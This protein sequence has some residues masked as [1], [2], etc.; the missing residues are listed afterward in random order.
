[1]KQLSIFTSLVLGLTAVASVG[2][3]NSHRPDPPGTVT[4]SWAIGGTTCTATGVAMVEISLLTA[5]AVETTTTVPCQ[6]GTVDVSNILPGL[7]T[8]KVDGYIAGQAVPSYTGT[9]PEVEVRSGA[10]TIVPRIQMSE[11]PGGLDVTWKFHDGSLCAFAGVDTINLNVWDSHSN[12]IKEEKL[13]CDPAQAVATAEAADP[14]RALYTTTRGIVMDGLYAG[15]Y[16]LRA[17]AL[18]QPLDDVSP[19]QYKYFAESKPTISHS[20]ITP[21]D[22]VLQPC[23]GQEIC[24]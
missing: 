9:L 11:S 20:Q 17:F 22:L 16:T 10:V 4:L 15:Q 18:K 5:E 6:L 3:G 12:L 19:V 14:T 24:F 1:M 7:Y 8:V 23:L 2:C 21:V 13:P